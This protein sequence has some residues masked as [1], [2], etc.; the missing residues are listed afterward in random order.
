TEIRYACEEVRNQSPA[1]R[2]F[3]VTL[4]TV[5]PLY[6]LA[7][8]REKKIL[9]YKADSEKSSQLTVFIDKYGKT[10]ESVRPREPI[11]PFGII[12]DCNETKCY[13]PPGRLSA[14]VLPEL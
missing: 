5:P 10:V 4:Q 6:K 14:E 13:F 2:F 8:S 12:V 9:R 7:G 11:N 1:V 3:P